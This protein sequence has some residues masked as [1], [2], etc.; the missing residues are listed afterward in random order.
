MLNGQYKKKLDDL[1]NACR[2][3]LKTVN[4][5]LITRAFKISLEAHKHDLRASGEPYFHHP[6]E[7][8]MIVAKE[9]PLDDLSVASALLHDVVED[10]EYGVERIRDEFGEAIANI[11]D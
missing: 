4:E 3:N 5:D 2:K 9:I 11:V 1:L 6:F 7:V 10:T 8:A